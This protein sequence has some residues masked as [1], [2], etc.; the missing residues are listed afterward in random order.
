[1]AIIVVMTAMGAPFYMTLSRSNDLDAAT[2]LL[3]QDLYQ[4]QAYS[5]NRTQ[6]SQWGVAVN[7]QVIT[8]FSGSDYASRNVANDVVYT[9]PGAIN[10]SGTNQIV[11]S[12]MY[13]LPQAT[14]SFTLTGGGKTSTIVVNNKGM[15]EY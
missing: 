15:V 6:D 4:A 10:I 1:M 9:V 8:L 7:G 3:A 12:K 11:Y 13:G 2:S 5:R 14:A